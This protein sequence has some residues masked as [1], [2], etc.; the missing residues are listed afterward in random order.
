M[1]HETGRETMGEQTADK[2]I[3]W[4][5]PVVRRLAANRAE[6]GLNPCNDGGG[7]GCGPEVGN[8]S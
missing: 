7:G 2:R 6:G 1:S 4:E 5:R 8:H 3:S